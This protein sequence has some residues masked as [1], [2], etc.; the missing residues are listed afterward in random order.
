MKNNY[1]EKEKQIFGG[2]LRLAK[3]GVDLS[4]ITAQQIADSAGVGKA[5]IY[6]Y[7]S[8]KEDIV[9]GALLYSISAEAARFRQAMADTPLFADKMGLIYGGIVSHTENTGSAFSLVLNSGHSFGPGR[10][11]ACRFG[12]ELKERIMEFI[13]ILYDV[14][15]AG[16][17]QGVLAM[18][19]NNPRQRDY[20]HMVLFGSLSATAQSACRCAATDRSRVAE[21]AYTMLVK[22]LN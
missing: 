6:D 17:S 14:L 16:Y 22:A 13:R 2:V 11:N 15:A 19:I 8:S 10:D 7:F 20:V 1:T 3:S 21:N 9:Q 4:K 12:S 5:T 18:D